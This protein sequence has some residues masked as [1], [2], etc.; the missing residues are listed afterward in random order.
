MINNIIPG[1]A[2]Y[3]PCIMN[4]L[5]NALKSKA[6]VCFPLLLFLAMGRRHP[7]GNGLDVELSVSDKII[8]IFAE[9]Q[10]SAVADGEHYIM[11]DF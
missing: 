8:R 9:T 3:S 10:P 1:M 6:G 11:N 4:D 2:R 7:A 5:E